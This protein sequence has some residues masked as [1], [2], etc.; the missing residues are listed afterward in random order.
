[1]VLLSVVCQCVCVCVCV[2]LRVYVHMYASAFLKECASMC[3][4][5]M[6]VCVHACVHV[7]VCVCVCARM[8]VCVCVC[9]CMCAHV[10][11]CVCVSSLSLC[12]MTFATYCMSKLCCY[13]KKQ[14]PWWFGL[15]PPPQEGRVGLMR[16]HSTSPIYAA[17]T[18][19]CACIRVCESIDVIHCLQ[20][21]IQTNSKATTV[22]CVCRSTAAAV[23]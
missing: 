4:M 22:A 1:M 3:D 13:T 11:V 18:G 12:N 20:K 21:H 19:A 17:L 15:G 6:C 10:C 16:C 9:V 7:C 8:C 14:I 23:V 5:Y 2:C